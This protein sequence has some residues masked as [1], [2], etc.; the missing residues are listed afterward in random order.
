M[1]VQ[2]R[3]P[4]HHRDKSE[5]LTSPHRALSSQNPRFTF[6]GCRHYRDMDHLAALHLHALPQPPRA[7]PQQTREAKLLRAHQR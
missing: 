1:R 6:P 5:S 2:I 7:D 4:K 3:E